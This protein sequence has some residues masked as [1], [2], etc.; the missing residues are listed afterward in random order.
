MG[1]SNFLAK[2]SVFLHIPLFFSVPFGCFKA[3]IMK[4][5]FNIIDGFSFETTDGGYSSTYLEN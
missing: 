1:V 4:T 3:D 2:K 5:C